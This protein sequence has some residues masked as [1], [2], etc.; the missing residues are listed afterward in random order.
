MT[1]EPDPLKWNML[2]NLR[3]LAEQDHRPDYMPCG[4]LTGVFLNT[5]ADRWE[6]L[7]PRGLNPILPALTPP[8]PIGDQR[9]AGMVEG[10]R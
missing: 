5:C 2:A 1:S 10:G 8:N 4:V 6:A 3:W 9:D 7:I